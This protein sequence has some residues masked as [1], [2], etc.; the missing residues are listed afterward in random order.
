M[1]SFKVEARNAVGYSAASSSVDIQTATIPDK[2]LAPTTT[3]NGINVDISWVAPADN[4]SP[5]SSYT[6]QIRQSNAVTYSIDFTNCN[7]SN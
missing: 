4:G 1:Y 5:I 6:I 3:L 7:G 2:P